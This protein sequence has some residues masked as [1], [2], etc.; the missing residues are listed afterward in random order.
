MLISTTYPKSNSRS[1]IDLQKHR[2]RYFTFQ[3]SKQ[4][5][6]PKSTYMLCKSGS[7]SHKEHNKIGFAIF[8]FFYELILNLQSTGPHSKTGKNLLALSPLGLLNLHNYALAFNTQALGDESLSQ[9][10]P[11]AA[12]QARRWRGRAGGGK[13]ARGMGDWT[14]VWPIRGGGSDGEAFGDGR[15]EAVAARPPRL[16]L[17]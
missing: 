13:Q 9:Q 8:G 14:H 7:S 17:W 16:G 10:C 5:L 15:R 11:P 4:K 3:F 2:S 1:C 6:K 12:G